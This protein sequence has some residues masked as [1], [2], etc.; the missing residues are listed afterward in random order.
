LWCEHVCLYVCIPLATVR[1]EENLVVCIT[2]RAC[3]YIYI[4]L[5]IFHN[6]KNNYMLWHFS[7]SL[8]QV[9]SSTNLSGFL[10]LALSEVCLVT[11][12]ENPV[13]RREM[14]RREREC[15]GL[16]VQLRL[17]T[18]IYLYTHAFS[19]THTATDTHT[20]THTHTHLQTNNSLHHF[21]RTRS[22]W[23]ALLRKG[24]VFLCD[25]EEEGWCDDDV[26]VSLW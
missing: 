25:D 10:S 21:L 4:D 2:L 13:W 11:E 8:L 19:H 24:T 7:L 6:N 23:V 5:S 22:D 12:R 18:Y 17:Y 3:V 1:R 9:P 16:F 14:Q 20:H 26:L 15:R